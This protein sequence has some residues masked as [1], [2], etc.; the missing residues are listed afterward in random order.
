MDLSMNIRQLKTFLAI[1]HHGTF[2]RAATAV[3]LIKSAVSQQIS[4]LE[5]EL[6][7]VLFDRNK[8]SPA[9]T[10]DGRRLVKAE[11]YHP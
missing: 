11:R 8:R 1:A 10:F 3:H 4:E 9:F 5:R 7:L 6:Q 2:S